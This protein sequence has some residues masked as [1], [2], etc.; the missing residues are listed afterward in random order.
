M[1]RTVRKL[2]VAAILPLFC[3]AAPAF[4]KSDSGD[5]NRLVSAGTADTAVQGVLPGT[6]NPLL[7]DAHRTAGLT[8]TLSDAGIALPAGGLEEA[9][10]GFTTLNRCLGAL[11]IA[12]NVRVDGGFAPVREMLL[13]DGEA[14]L[15]DVARAFAPEVDPL[16]A[17]R[18][19]Q[20]QAAADLKKAGIK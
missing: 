10:A 12:K 20:N 11:H 5:S 4:A 17:E 6:A 7:R 2:A 3:A 9:C 16:D 1:S 19:A 18:M 8:R 14:S 15:G 13:Y